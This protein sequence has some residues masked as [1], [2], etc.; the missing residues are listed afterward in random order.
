MDCSG[1]LDFSL[2]F[3]VLGRKGIAEYKL[4]PIR[5]YSWECFHRYMICVKMYRR[6][7]TFSQFKHILEIFATLLCC[8]LSPQKFFSLRPL[9]KVCVPAHPFN[10]R[11]EGEF[12]DLPLERC[13]VMSYSG[14][15]LHHNKNEHRLYSCENC[16]IEEC[17]WVDLW[18][19][20]FLHLF[21]FPLCR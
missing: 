18:T 10:A 15:D 1:A 2:V 13:N 3:A 11:V 17:C 14:G 8:G 21:L 12:G 5:S 7:I 20:N 19:W 9:L 6:N 4:F 16:G